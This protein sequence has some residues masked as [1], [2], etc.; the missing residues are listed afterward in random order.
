MALFFRSSRGGR[1][2]LH[3]G[4]EY[5][6]QKVHAEKVRKEFPLCAAGLLQFPLYLVGCVILDV[7]AV[8]SERTV[9]SQGTHD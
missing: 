9:Q 5:D 7:L 8:Q 2:L 4:F 6:K 1:K 3:D